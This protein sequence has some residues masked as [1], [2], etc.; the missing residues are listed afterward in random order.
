[1]HDPVAEIG[2]EY[3]PQLG[4][5]G[6][7]ADR[8][9]WPVRALLNIAGKLR[10]VFEQIILESERVNRTSFPFSAIEPGPIYRG[11]GEQ[12]TLSRTN[13]AHIIAI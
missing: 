7:K 13:G 5:G 10:Q 12:F 1:M 8:A 2:R 6:D 3:L 9:G 11:K 4:A